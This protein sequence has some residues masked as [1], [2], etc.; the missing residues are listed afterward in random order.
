MTLEQRA[1][2]SGIFPGVS[3]ALPSR[4][5]GSTGLAVSALGLGAGRIGG[6]ETTDSEV[7]RLLGAALELGV[8]LVDTAR[9]YGASEERLGRALHGRRDSVVLSTKLGYGIPGVPDWTGAAVDAGVNDALERLRTDRLEIVHLHSC[10]REVLERGEVIEAL[11]RAVRAGKVRVPAYSGE[12]EAL[13][14]AV[15]SGAFGV[16]QCSVSLVD[17][18]VRSGAV[19]EAERRGVGVLAK[20]PLGNA[21]WRFESRPD[22][23]DVAEA[24]ERFGVLLLDPAGLP[25]DALAAR[26]AAFTPGVSAILLG[27]S[28]PA[29]LALAATAIAEGPL[30]EA[31][32]ASI[33]AAHARVGE[34]WPGR[35]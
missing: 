1:R 31:V 21:P 18:G 3:A 6:P 14:W 13:D 30:P 25:W 20:R 16:V 28:S 34:G 27:T 5:L 12:N 10:P 15:R 9:S 29:H 7:D 17:Q 23:S 22:A 11:H 2:F 26:F 24:W 33:H 35:I 4:P 32:L 8:R 19:P